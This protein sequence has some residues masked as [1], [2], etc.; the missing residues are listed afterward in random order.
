[1]DCDEKSKNQAVD[2]LTPNWPTSFLMWI[3]TSISDFHLR[4]TVQTYT[5]NNRYQI[6][7]LETV[8][9]RNATSQ[10]LPAER[11]V[12]PAYN[13]ENGETF[14][15]AEYNLHRNCRYLTLM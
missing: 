6:G 1:M 15:F 9:Q 2:A 7:Q 5:F 3:T 14:G 11:F 4:Q 10:L 12:N 13:K 8:Y